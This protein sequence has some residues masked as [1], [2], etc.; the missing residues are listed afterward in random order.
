MGE[1]LK[2]EILFYNLPA[3]IRK[4]L[5]EA[6]GKNYPTSQEILTKY[7]EVVTKLNL[8]DGPNQPKVSVKEKVITSSAQANEVT[9]FNVS[10][11]KGNQLSETKCL[12][13]GK[14]HRS[15]NCDVVKDANARENILKTK[16]PKLCYKCGLT[17]HPKFDKCLWRSYCNEKDC[18]SSAKHSRLYCP[19]FCKNSKVIAIKQISSVP[20]LVHSVGQESKSV[21]LPTGIFSVKNQRAEKLP[22]E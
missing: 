15:H 22:V 2:R 6:T 7:E 4:G 19:K 16:H 8:L 13:C 18:S 11:K 1:E 10:H 12:F 21:A 17:K 20:A 14:Q 3:P 9:T 5:I